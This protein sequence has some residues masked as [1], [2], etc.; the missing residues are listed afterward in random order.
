MQ[1]IQNLVPDFIVVH[2]KGIYPKVCGISK[3]SGWLQNGYADDS[4]S[5]WLMGKTCQLT[6]DPGQ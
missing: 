6:P 1:A 5:K 3:K 2:A 4:T